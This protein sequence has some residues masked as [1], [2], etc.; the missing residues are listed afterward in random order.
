MKKLCARL[1][2]AGTLLAGV[3]GCGN[4]PPEY[5]PAD[6]P[7]P[8]AHRDD[9]VGSPSNPWTTSHNPK[10]KQSGKR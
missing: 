8:A 6:P 2:V 7:P 1:L 5:N 9:P 3:P 4:K 10:G